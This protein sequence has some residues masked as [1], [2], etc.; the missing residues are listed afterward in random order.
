MVEISGRLFVETPKNRKRRR[1]IYPR[2]TPG[3]WPLAGMAARIE[4]VRKEQEAGTSPLGQRG[5][6]SG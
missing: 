1:T 4:D 6:P 2:F 5:R 3:G